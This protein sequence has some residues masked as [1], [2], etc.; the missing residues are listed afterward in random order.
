MNLSDR[1][2]KA[3]QALSQSSLDKK[4]R[5]EQRSSIASGLSNFESVLTPENLPPVISSQDDAAN[6]LRERLA[7]LNQIQARNEQAWVPDHK[8]ETVGGMVGQTAAVVKD[9]GTRTVTGIPE[10]LAQNQSML[11]LSRMDEDAKAPFLRYANYEYQRNAFENE[12]AGT[13]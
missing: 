3:A 4:E 8:L 9:L 10:F 7:H 6:K 13:I 12:A 5:V 11:S 2:V 1:L